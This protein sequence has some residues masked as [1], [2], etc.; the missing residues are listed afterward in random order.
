MNIL[1]FENIN[2]SYSKNFFEK[3]FILNLEFKPYL[4]KDLIINSVGTAHCNKFSSFIHALKVTITENPDYNRRINIHFANDCI[5]FD[6]TLVGIIAL[7]KNSFPTIKFEIKLPIDEGGGIHAKFR[8]NLFFLREWY[9][10]FTNQELFTFYNEK[11]LVSKINEPNFPSQLIFLITQNS[12]NEYFV[13]TNSSWNANK[14]FDNIDKKRVAESLKIALNDNN[15]KGES[16]AETNYHILRGIIR[17]FNND[18]KWENNNRIFYQE[19]LRM[20]SNFDLSNEIINNIESSDFENIRFEKFIKG[21]FKHLEMSNLKDGFQLV[22]SKLLQQPSFFIFLYCFLVNRNIGTAIIKDEIDNGKVTKNKV[23]VLLTRLNELFE[24]TKNLFH[25]IREIARNIIDHTETKTGVL[26]GRVYTSNSLFEIKGRDDLTEF[27][28]CLKIYSTAL[29]NLKIENYNSKDNYFLDLTIFD[30]GQDGV[31]KKTISNIRNL[32]RS[33]NYNPDLY[34]KDISLLSNGEIRLSDFFNVNEIKLYHHAVKTAS[35]W[36][37]IIFSNL[38]NKNNGFFTVSSRNLFDSKLIDSC[39]AYL[40]NNSETNKVINP[41]YIGTYYNII[42]PLD[43]NQGLK[44]ETKQILKA[45]EPNFSATNY[46]TLQKYKYLCDIDM[47]KGSYDKLLVNIPIVRFLNDKVALTYRGEIDIADLVGLR[48]KELCSKNKYFIPVLDFD[49]CSDDFDQSKL[50][51]FL[52]RL[53]LTFDIDN[54]IVTNVKATNI[55]PLKEIINI[56]DNTLNDAH[57]WNE[58]YFVLIFSYNL[59]KNHR[60]NYYTDILG[61]YTYSD[62]K[63]LRNKLSSTHQSFFNISYKNTNDTFSENTLKGIKSSPLFRSS[64]SGIIQNFELILNY[65][66][67]SYFE[68]SLENILNINVDSK[69]VDDVGYKIGDTHFRLG[70][71]IHITEFIYAKRIFQKSF[72]SDRFAFLIAK[73]I[74]DNFTISGNT[75]ILGYGGYSQLLVNRTTE[76]LKKNYESVLINNDI[77]SDIEELK[78]IKNVSLYN[79]IIVLVPINTTFST[80]IKIENMVR[81][82]VSDGAKFTIIPV[83]L[84]LVSHDNLE[85]QKYVDAL[86]YYLGTADNKDE[87]NRIYPYKLFHWKELNSKKKI[88]KVE[89]NP[90]NIR[91]T[92]QKY[93]ISITSHWALPD[94]C[95]KCFPILRNNSSIISI[96]HRLLERPLLETDKASVSPN[97][98]LDIPVNFKSDL[99]KVEPYIP[100]DT[101]YLNEDAHSSGHIFYRNTHYLNF[102]DPEKFYAKYIDEIIKWADNCRRKLIESDHDIINKSIL[103]I[104]SSNNNNAY[105]IEF[106]NRNVFKD[107]AIINHYEIGEDYLENFEKFFNNDIKQAEY[108]FFVDDFINSGSTFH[109]INDFVRYCNNK[110]VNR[111]IDNGSKNIFSCNGLFTLINKSDNY[112]QNDIISLL[113]RT[114]HEDPMFFSFYQWKDNQIKTVD[115]PICAERRRYQLLAENSMLDTVKHFF[116]NKAKNLRIKDDHF[117]DNIK[118]KWAKYHPLVIETDDLPWNED[119]S[120]RSKEL[121]ETYLNFYFPGKSYLKMLI[122]HSINE[123]FSDDIEIRDYL[124]GNTLDLNTQDN[125]ELNKNL[126]SLIVEKLILKKPFSIWNESYN[127]STRKVFYIIFKEIVIKILTQQPFINVKSIRE[128]VFAWIL[129]ELTENIQEFTKSD[130]LIFKRFRYFKFLLRRATLLGSNFIIDKKTLADIRILYAKYTDEKKL[131]IE[132]DRKKRLDD[133]SAWL[134]NAQKRK[135]EIELSIGDKKAI[136][137]NLLTEIEVNA[138]SLSELNDEL[139]MFSF[140]EKQEKIRI[141]NAKIDLFDKNLKLLEFQINYVEQ[142]KRNI[143]Y[144]DISLKEFCYF[145]VSLIKELTLNNES[146][147]LTIE[148]NVDS[149]IEL[150]K[151]NRE[152]DFYFLLRLIKF[153]NISIIN[154][155][156]KI[157]LN[158]FVKN[159]SNISFDNHCYLVREDIKFIIINALA[160]YR[161]SSFKQFFGIKDVSEWINTEECNYIIHLIYLLESLQKENKEIDSYIEPDSPEEKEILL[162]KKT[163]GLLRNLFRMICDPNFQNQSFENNTLYPYSDDKKSNGGFI[164]L[165]YRGISQKY[166]PPNNIIITNTTSIQDANRNIVDKKKLIET[167][168]DINSMSYLMLNGLSNI[169]GVKEEDINAKFVLKDYPLKPWTILDLS[170]KT[171][172]DDKY[173]N[174]NRGSVYPTSKKYLDPI[175]IFHYKD[176]GLDIDYYFNEFSVIDESCRYIVF[177]RIAEL[178]EINDK[179]INEGKAVFTFYTSNEEI[180]IERLRLMLLVCPDLNKFFAKHYEKDSL[181]ALIDER[182][183]LI[184]STRLKHGYSKFLGAFEYVALDDQIEP[185]YKKD[186][187]GLFKNHLETG[188]L[189]S[190]KIERIKYLGIEKMKQELDSSFKLKTY[191]KNELVEEIEKIVTIVYQTRISASIEKNLVPCFSFIDTPNDFQFIFYSK[192]FCLLITEIAI[193]AK[194]SQEEIVDYPKEL[195]IKISFNNDIL[196]LNFENNYANEI[197]GG[198]ITRLMKGNFKFSSNGLSMIKKICITFGGLKPI[199]NIYPKQKMFSISIEI[200]KIQP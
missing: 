176:G 72:F 58:N 11:S 2:D 15:L 63:K 147:V 90:P 37:L 196:M 106:I 77:I 81:D 86:N 177:Y 98:L 179:V 114:A 138:I 92:E 122:R 43:R 31:V 30:E 117:N 112:S 25:G 116:L 143:I 158:D 175:S 165:K 23:S 33:N 149:I 68:I 121:W 5:N 71:K 57:F 145:Y 137:V 171:L 167:E 197:K 8:D 174:V 6:I 49:L 170:L 153:E 60:R 18:L 125:I 51:R 102:I 190:N 88:V 146:K 35:H 180:P 69:D 187:I 53:Q 188:P 55:A 159:Q 74:K 7:F 54:L 46:H 65:N 82:K 191:S 111:N 27:S 172:G 67:K 1:D 124:T 140:G 93:F 129:I 21:G 162:D 99:I 3:S 61:G 135:I 9:L 157:I 151:S 108:I 110:N 104:S 105:F 189:L 85:D 198:E 168:I 29:N 73:Y 156:I 136:I 152:R 94:D 44:D 12:F 42:L 144:K 19:Y 64:E 66:N 166:I 91:T 50:L 22:I 120:A 89:T 109:L 148:R 193:N 192:I 164:A 101:I 182:E 14:L 186:I 79:I 173:W 83:N 128:R 36:G 26:T 184:E 45:K 181:I 96:D 80:A 34:A 199:I 131:K 84:I 39:F 160:H 134:I 126:F 59:D 13:S 169:E 150:V 107:S 130:I 70:S 75:T 24:F 200:K 87:M 56:D 194:K 141:L 183:R 103:L 48:I 97:L 163:E 16:L 154:R 185:S 115:C 100:Q 4:V 28:N 38:I 118:I 10:N 32:S 142:T 139:K 178:T 20:L 127:Q 17:K 95:E 41:F 195:S 62:L 123:L 161:L 113:K 76:I 78:Q 52:S 132:N 155:S 40:G 119:S 133:L 47:L